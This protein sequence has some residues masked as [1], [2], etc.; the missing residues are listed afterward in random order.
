MISRFRLLLA[1]LVLASLATPVMAQSAAAS[2]TGDPVYEK[3]CAKCHGKTAEGRHFGGPSLATG[4]LSADE[5]KAIIANGKGRMPKYAGKLTDDQITALAS[6][7][8]ALSAA[9]QK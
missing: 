5:T 7:I 3:N 2:L 4:K 1:S 8:K 9:P 6:E